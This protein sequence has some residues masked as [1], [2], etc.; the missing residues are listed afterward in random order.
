MFLGLFFQFQTVFACELMDSK[1]KP[2]CCCDESGDMT[3]GCGMNGNCQDE[4]ASFVNA[5]DCC[6]KNY[7]TPP[8]VKSTAPG[9]A[10]TQVLLLDGPQPPPVVAVF[11]VPEFPFPA[12][13]RS[14]TLFLTPDISGIHTYLLTQRL[15]I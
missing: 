15:R 4:A 1:P 14:Y 8:S 6:E 13:T 7:Q 5:V 11:H 12:V 10:N 2:V 3:M 9:A